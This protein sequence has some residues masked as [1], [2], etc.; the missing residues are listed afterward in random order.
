MPNQIKGEKYIYLAMAYEL[1]K[2]QPE[3]T[4]QIGDDNG[5][6]GGQNYYRRF[7]IMNYQD[8]ILLIEKKISS[9]FADFH[10]AFLISENETTPQK[11]YIYEYIDEYGDNGSKTWVH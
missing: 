8:K 7:S 4:I 2:R 5:M 9:H 6:K 1:T 3:K 10:R 11:P